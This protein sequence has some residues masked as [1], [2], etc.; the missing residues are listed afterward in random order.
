MDVSI[1]GGMLHCSQKTANDFVFHSFGGIF[2]MI[3][4]T[5]PLAWKKISR[6]HAITIPLVSLIIGHGVNAFVEAFLNQWYFDNMAA[7]T[8]IINAIVAATFF[9]AW[10]KTAIATASL[11]S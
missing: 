10:K 6:R 3:V 11:N 8:I 7:A 1:F 9:V 4:L 2:A 5:A